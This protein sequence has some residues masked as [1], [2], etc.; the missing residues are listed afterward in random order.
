MATWER[1]GFLACELVEGLAVQVQKKQ[2]FYHPAWS[3]IQ[4]EHQQQWSFPTAAP[5]G[6]APGCLDT[7]TLPLALLDICELPTGSQ[8]ICFLC[9]ILQGILCLT[10]TEIKKNNNMGQSMATRG[11]VVLY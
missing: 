7:A 1:T 5:W 3:F 10:D 2:R 8:Q 11:W 9:Y 6:P 4:A